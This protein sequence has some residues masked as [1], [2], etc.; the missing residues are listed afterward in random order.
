[1]KRGMRQQ[2]KTVATGGKTRHF[3]NLTIEIATLIPDLP[4]ELQ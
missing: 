2:Q 3:G 1:V 4:R